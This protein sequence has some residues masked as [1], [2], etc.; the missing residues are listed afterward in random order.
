MPSTDDKTE[1]RYFDKVRSFIEADSRRLAELIDNYREL[2]KEQGG[3]FNEDNPIGGMYS[4]TEL[5]ELHYE[6]ENEMI[7]AQEAD[8]DIHFY[9]KLIKAPY[10]ARVDFT[11]DRNGKK[12]TVYIGLKTLQEPDTYNMLVCDWRAPVSAL[13]YDEFESSRASFT[14]PAGVIEGELSLKRQFKFED[15]EL[16]YYVDSDVKIDDDILREVLS[17]S[18]GEHLKVIVNS[19]QREQNKAIRFSESENLLVTG[20]AGS[21]KT[22]VGFHRLAFLLYKNR[23]DL[24]SSEIVMFSNNDIFSSYV[25]DIIP[26]LGEMP[27]NY[28]SF[29]TIFAAEL[30]SYRVSD[31]YELADELIE[32]VKVRKQSVSVKYSPDF[33]PYLKAAADDFNPE[34]QDITL[35]DDWV[36]IPA[37]TLEERF[38]SDVENTTSSRG[39]RLSEYANRLIDDYFEKNYK[40]IFDRI[41]GE[42]SIDEDTSRL[43]TAQRRYLKTEA[44]RAIRGITGADPVSLYCT[45]LKN[46]VADKNFDRKIYECTVNDAEHGRLGFEDAL[47][48]VYLKF[49]LGT[50]AVIPN[51]KHILIDEAQDLSPLQHAI[52]R[53]MFPRADFTLLADSNQAILPEINSSDLETMAKVYSAKTLNLYKSYRSAKQ[54]NE[55]ALSLLPPQKRYDI[56]EREGSPVRFE[57][58]DATLGKTVSLIREYTS[59]SKRN[60][61][62]ITKTARAAES[63]H[64]RLKKHFP[65]INLCNYKSAQ[66]NTAPT[67]M[68]LA[69]TKG[70]EFDCVIVVNEKGCFDGDENKGYL[71]MASTRA[72]HEL[73]IIDM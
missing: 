34:F 45:A 11:P 64:A 19:I 13:F 15:G 24:V 1:Q 17:K 18:S 47:C 69:L 72:L 60:V 6:M 4:G 32:G 55:F 58:D 22:S 41:D 56:F 20:A 51:V 27:I 42:T 44:A 52:I 5:T 36:V 65:K 59:D 63:L 71:Y 70:L 66:L 31:Y 7:R 28:A 49:F 40:E 50:A 62:I 10:F 3:K 68:N 39:E 37:E 26:E 14:A 61:C 8:N 33:L 9:K 16:K 53:L 21:G 73:A 57:T 43:V 67:V 30:P 35:F 38:V 48:I 29:Y 12:Q 25:A 2:I 23:R 54:I 46:F